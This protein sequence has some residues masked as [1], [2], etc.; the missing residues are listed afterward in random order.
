MR[1]V[2]G[3]ACMECCTFSVL[4]IRVKANKC[5]QWAASEAEFWLGLGRRHA[6]SC[7][8]HA[9]GLVLRGIN[10]HALHVKSLGVIQIV[11]D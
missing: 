5:V 1:S 8:A 4:C 7:R 2:E 6:A 9:N 10:H 3:M 11:R